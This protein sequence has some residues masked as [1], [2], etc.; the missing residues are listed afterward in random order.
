M[1]HLSVYV[2]LQVCLCVHVGITN[3]QMVLS[4]TA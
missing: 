2:I 1:K 4:L 3:K